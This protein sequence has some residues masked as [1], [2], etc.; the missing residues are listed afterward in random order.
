MRCPRRSR[1][2]RRIVHAVAHHRHAAA[3]ALELDH[4][5]LFA[6]RHHF[7]A[8]DVDPQVAPDRLRD[9]TRIAGDHQ[10]LEACGPEIGDRLPGF[11]ANGIL[12]RDTASACA[13]DRDACAS[14]TRR[15][16]PASVVSS[17]TAVTRTRTDESVAMVPPTIRSRGPA[18][19]DAT[20][21]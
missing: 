1:E 7:R 20:R 6:L 2:R 13:R 18:S 14:A 4:D 11:G 9:L 12:Q 3:I 8:H 15:R 10:H 5:G 17:P 16:I 19:R 21:R